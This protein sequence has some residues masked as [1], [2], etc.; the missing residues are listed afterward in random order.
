MLGIL[1][2]GRELEVGAPRVVGRGNLHGQ[3]TIEE[4]FIGTLDPGRGNLSTFKKG[5]LKINGF[6]T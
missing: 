2:E 1:A 5:D 3:G 4:D 6:N